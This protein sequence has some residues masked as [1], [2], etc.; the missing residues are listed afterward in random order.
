MNKT[1]GLFIDFENLIY[2]LV[3]RY[4]EQGTYELFKPQLL[5]DFAARHGQVSCAFAYA[6]WRMR[7]VNQWQVDL[8]GRGVELIHVLGRGGKNAVDI[9]MAV[10]LV[11]MVFTQPHL[12]T[13]MIVSGDRDFLPV[14][15]VLKRYGKRVI[16][17]APSRAMS[18]EMKRVCDLTM[19]YEGLLNELGELKQSEAKRSPHELLLEMI[20]LMRSCGP[21]GL[22][23]AQL[24][25]MLLQSRGGQFSERDYGFISFGMLLE[26]LATLSH[27]AGGITVVKPARGDLRVHLSLSE[28]QARVSSEE[29]AA[30]EQQT[31]RD[32]DDAKDDKAEW[33]DSAQ[34][35]YDQ[36][37]EQA[38]HHPDA[39]AGLGDEEADQRNRSV[40]ALA[41]QASK[42]SR[43]DT[44]YAFHTH[45]RSHELQ[46]ALSCL[47][48][49][50]YIQVAERRRAIL[51]ELYHVLSNPTG[52]VW[53]EALDEVCER[54]QLSRSQASKYHAILL[55]SQAF[56]PAL[57]GDDRPVK[58]RKLKLIESLDSPRALIARYEQSVLHKVICRRG[59]IN[60]DVAAD[61]L[62]V[63]IEVERGELERLVSV[64][65][66][67]VKETP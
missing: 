28:D 65:S 46:L 14:I 34:P 1:V 54:A 59:G 60:L 33:D 63:D 61:L 48:G 15:N 52:V 24:K 64:A 10:D 16:A 55:Q 18:R 41:D 36:A 31:R 6:D 57:P 53:A 2:G 26:H 56:N 11:E 21:E 29:R 40:S 51:T 39:P 12:D 22:T 66:H 30:H 20:E 43:A 5:F 17:L 7:A 4:G 47:K 42:S 35:R 37:A 38:K 44:R 3:D 50:Q 23:G 58:H 32:Q 45:Q 62:G 13:Y 67:E 9:K 25:Q 27:S 8:Y 49:Y 19:T